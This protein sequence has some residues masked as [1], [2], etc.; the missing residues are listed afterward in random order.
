MSS[1]QVQLWLAE[2]QA[3]FGQVLRTP[4]SV[5]DG[6]L[7]SDVRRYPSAAV[8]DV[9]PGSKLTAAERLSVYQRQYWMRLLQVLQEQ[10]PLTTHLCGAWTLN[11]RAITFLLEHP[12]RAHDLGCIADGFARF[13]ERHH[14]QAAPRDHGEAGSQVPYEAVLEAARIDASYRRVF[15]APP[16]Q[17]WRLG[18]DAPADLASRRLRVSGALAIVH[19]HWPLVR[20]RAAIFERPGAAPTPLPD[21]M[22]HAQAWAVY[23][24]REGMMHMPLAADQARLLELLTDHSLGDALATLERETQDLASLPARVHSYLAQAMQAGFFTGLC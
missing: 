12:P 22:G 23:R 13:L 16:Q 17:T 2:L 9:L 19:E 1:A 3:R 11:L 4:L 14:P 20:L 8:A 5:V 6:S 21:R 7:Q 18:R 15:G 10:Y 24:S